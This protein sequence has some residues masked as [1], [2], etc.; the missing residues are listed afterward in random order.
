MYVH[1]GND[2]VLHKNDVLGIFDFDLLY[3]SEY[4]KKHFRELENDNRLIAITQ[5]VPKSVV[6]AFL[7]GEEVAYLSP[8]SPKTIQNRKIF[9]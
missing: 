6:I 4:T 3:M 9:S 7:S 5:D 1:I 2:F 8:L